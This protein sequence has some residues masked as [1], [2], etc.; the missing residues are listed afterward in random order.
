M[1]ETGEPGP[2]RAAQCELQRRKR[3][4]G[5]ARG[6]RSG[7]GQGGGAG[8]QEGAGLR[9]GVCASQQDMSWG[10]GPPGRP[11]QSLSPRGGTAL[12][13]EPRSVLTVPVIISDGKD[14]FILLTGVA[15]WLPGTHQ[16]LCGDG[17][18]LICSLER[19]SASFTRCS[20]GASEFRQAL[21]EVW[22][23]REVQM[24]VCLSVPPGLETLQ[25]LPF[26]PQN[27]PRAPPSLRPHSPPPPPP[28][29]G[30]SLSFRKALD[31]I[32]PARG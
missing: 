1:S 2:I 18:S 13:Y 28:R 30:S 26:S 6:G 10:E 29:L 3:R 9:A 5:M 27:Q 8:L 24:Q 15:S 17:P 19:F 16:P 4:R 22:P 21:G 12:S 25:G 23:Q 7:Q 32:R 20:E 11:L 31:C 14:K